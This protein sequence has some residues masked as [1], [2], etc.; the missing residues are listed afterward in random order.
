MRI[1]ASSNLRGSSFTLKTGPL[2][3]GRVRKG[4]IMRA[5]VFCHRGRSAG[6]VSYSGLRVGVEVENVHA[7]VSGKHLRGARAG[8]SGDDVEVINVRS[9]RFDAIGR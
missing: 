2:G 7:E 5:G 8:R 1:Y 4:A 6:S 9:G 3:N